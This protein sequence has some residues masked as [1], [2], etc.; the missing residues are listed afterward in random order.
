M[1]RQPKGLRKFGCRNTEVG[2]TVRG[3][4]RMVAG[5]AL[6][7]REAGVEGHVPEAVEGPLLKGFPSPKEK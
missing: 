2:A 4:V 1:S 3:A 6:L 7:V 5:K